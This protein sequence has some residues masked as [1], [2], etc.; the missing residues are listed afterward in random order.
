MGASQGREAVPLR[1]RR[2]VLGC[3][4]VT[5]KAVRHPSPSVNWTD[6]A[7][8]LAEALAALRPGATV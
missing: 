6:N 2:A 8:D 3:R 4:A 7:L 5:G 1:W